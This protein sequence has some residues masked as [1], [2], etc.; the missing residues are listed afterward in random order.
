MQ[1]AAMSAPQLRRAPRDRATRGG[2]KPPRV[3]GV[4]AGKST[5]PTRPG[6]LGRAPQP[7]DHSRRCRQ[8][9]TGV[10]ICFSA[11]KRES[12][13]YDLGEK[14]PVELRPPRR[15]ALDESDERVADA[16]AVLLHLGVEQLRERGRLSAGILGFQPQAGEAHRGAVGQELLDPLARRV[17]L[18]AVAG[19]RGDERT[20]ARI[21]L[22]TQLHPLRPLHDV[23]ELVLVERE[24]DVVDSRH[25]PL[26]R[27]DDDVDGTP[28]E[29]GES[30]AKAEPVE[31]LPR[32]AR[33]VVRLLVADPAVARDEA[34]AELRDVAG[35]YVPHLARHEVVVEELHGIYA[36]PW[37][38]C[39]TCGSARTGPRC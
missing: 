27:L 39:T 29:L 1:W 24:P 6:R 36:R 30:Q 18:D 21:F 12:T 11:H 31:L 22:H 13:T 7:L 9:D 15:T 3:E 33:L 8:R 17:H 37:C 19:A 5:E 26:A 16:N 35:F 28:L 25:V 4:E 32:H 23:D 14:L 38:C 34:E 10:C 2:E 20:A